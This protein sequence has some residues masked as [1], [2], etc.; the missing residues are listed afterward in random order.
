MVGMALRLASV[1]NLLTCMLLTRVFRDEPISY[2]INEIYLL[3]FYLEVPSDLCSSH[4]S[5]SC[6]LDQLLALPEWPRPAQTTAQ[7]FLPMAVSG[8]E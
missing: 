2:C 1:L 6:T 5:R 8:L 7:Y 4:P 3:T